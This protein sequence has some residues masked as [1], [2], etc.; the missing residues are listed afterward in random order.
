VAEARRRPGHRPFGERPFQAS[1]VV[2]GITR[3]E[4][5]AALLD[6]RSFPEWASGLRRVRMLGADGTETP[7]MR[8]GTVL[9]FSLS[10]AGMT[11]EVESAVTTVEAP[12][13]LEWGY[14]KGAIGSG[15]WLIEAE[16]PNATR[17][18]LS[19][20]YTVK[21]AWLDRLAH[22]PFFRGLVE[23]LLKRSMRRFEEHL[24]RSP[25]NRRT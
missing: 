2:S 25:T 21:P 4:I 19:T 15:G 10:A 22:R 20:D 1:Y 23:D 13:L 14:K 24:R 11:H 16:G 6:A 7:E 12:R 8:P 17:M 18:T 9:V 3:E 5:F